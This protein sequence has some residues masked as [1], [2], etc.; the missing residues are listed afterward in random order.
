LYS[1]VKKVK[2]QVISCVCMSVCTLQGEWL[3]L[4]TSAGLTHDP[5]VK[6]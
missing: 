1:T 3:E 6:K 4:S 5:E 2:N